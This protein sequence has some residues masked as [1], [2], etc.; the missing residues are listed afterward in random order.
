MLAEVVDEACATIVMVFDAV[1]GEPDLA[2]FVSWCRT[3]GIITVAPSPDPDA[4]DPIDPEAVDVVV[5]P[6]LAFTPDGRRLGQ[7]GGWY[8]RFLARTRPDC[9]GIGVA[10]D[11]QIVDD[12]PTE[13][14][15]VLLELV[16]TESGRVERAGTN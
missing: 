6:G 12:V 3:R 8:D 15:D 9:L 11:V 13:Q 7:G 5:V 14:H 10:F 16:I 2:E 4:G 1:P